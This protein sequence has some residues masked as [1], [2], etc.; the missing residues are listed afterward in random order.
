MSAKAG[1]VV[2]TIFIAFESMADP[3][4]FSPPGDLEPGSGMGVTDTTLY[5]K[6][7]RF[8]LERSPAYL[9][10]QVYRKGGNHGP[11]GGQCDSANYSYPW[12]DNFCETRGWDMAVCPSNKGHQGQDI[13]P[14]TC[15]PDVHWAVAVEDG[16][17]A[18][19][20]SYSVTLQTPSG[21]LYRYLH[22]QMDDLAVRRLDTIKKGQ[23]IGKVSNHFG[24][25]K[26]TIHLHFD[27]KDSLVYKGVRQSI[28]VPPYASLVESYTRLLAEGK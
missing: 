9:N 23:R 5:F 1:L 25:A 3:G 19:I 17:I 6:E 26:T 14:A 28:F 27:I 18:Q 13:R 4:R 21:T 8:P 10:S 12:R 24:G 16:I 20:G 7:I 11:A 15:K 22:L 2:L